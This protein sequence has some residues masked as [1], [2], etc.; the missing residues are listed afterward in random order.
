VFDLVL[1]L[2]HWANYHLGGVFNRL[3]ASGL[4][5]AIDEGL[6]LIIFTG[7]AIAEVGLIQA[8]GIGTVEEE[9]HAFEHSSKE[10]VEDSSHL[11]EQRF[12]VYEQLLKK[13]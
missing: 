10:G 5:F 2:R 3:Y 13:R 9:F 7:L 8:L 11:P 4:R 6:R 12:V 1:N